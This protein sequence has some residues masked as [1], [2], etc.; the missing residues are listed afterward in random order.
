MMRISSNK[1]SPHVVAHENFVQSRCRT[2]Q[3]IPKESPNPKIGPKKRTRPAVAPSPSI[4]EIMLNR[5]EPVI[6]RPNIAR[7]V[8][9]EAPKRK[10]YRGE[11]ITQIKP[12]VNQELH[13]NT[14]DSKLEYNRRDIWSRLEIKYSGYL[15]RVPSSYDN[16]LIPLFPFN[17]ALP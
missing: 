13:T 4:L 15:A 14:R 8:E 3:A 10:P 12:V 17:H 11:Q 6:E 2:D 1:I 7:P 5:K 16:Y 9:D